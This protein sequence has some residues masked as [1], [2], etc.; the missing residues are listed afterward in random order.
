M[1]RTCTKPS[2]R[3]LLLSRKVDDLL[4][5]ARGLVLVRGLLAERG[6]TAGE[7]Q[8]HTAELTKVRRKL[9]ELI[10]DAGDPERPVLRP[11]A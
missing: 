9:A 4:L 5:Q 7:L 1:N 11:V 6:A 10:G 8:A 2:D 3:E